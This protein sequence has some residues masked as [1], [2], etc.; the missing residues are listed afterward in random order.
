MSTFSTCIDVFPAI[1][2]SSRRSPEYRQP[3]RL[4]SGSAD[5]VIANVH[6][7]WSANLN[8]SV[9][10]LRN[11]R[12]GW[13]GPGSREICKDSLV[14]AIT[15]VRQALE[16]LEQAEAPYLVPGGDGSVQVEWH[17]RHGELELTVG[18]NGSL[19]IWGRNHNTGAEFEDEDEEALVLFFR[20]AAWVAS[21]RFNVGDETVAKAASFN[22]L[23]A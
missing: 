13:D 23:D 14:R 4:K 7:A 19:S 21:P 6:S 3:T 12:K 20:W 17:E 9:A 2:F 8:Q 10:R 1:D 5:T 11:L 22:E 18:V 16:G 15:L